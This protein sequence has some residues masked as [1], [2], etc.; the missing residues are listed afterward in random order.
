MCV[1]LHYE[2]F[3]GETGRPSLMLLKD[4]QRI[5]LGMFDGATKRVTMR[6]RSTRRLE[7]KEECRGSKE[8]DL[9]HRK[10]NC[11]ALTIPF[12]TAVLQPVSLCA[13]SSEK[14]TFL[15]GMILILVKGQDTEDFVFSFLY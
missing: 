15:K 4:R 1:S 8:E 9:S 6:A 13:S 11:L 2:R 12:I 5:T 14:K 10:E 3:E 7:I